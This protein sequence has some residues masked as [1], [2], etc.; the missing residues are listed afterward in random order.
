MGMM[1]YMEQ[2]MMLEWLKPERKHEAGEE[3]SE[4]R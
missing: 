2:G 3:E 4:R 1:L